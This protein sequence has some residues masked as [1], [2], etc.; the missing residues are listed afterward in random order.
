MKNGINTG[1]FLVKTG[2]RGNG[3]KNPSPIFV[4]TKTGPRKYGN[5]RIKVENGMNQNR[6]FSV[7]FQRYPQLGLLGADLEVHIEQ[8]PL[9]LGLNPTVHLEC[10][11]IF[12]PQRSRQ[13]VRSRQIRSYTP[14]R[15]STFEVARDL[16]HK[17][18]NSK[19]SNTSREIGSG[20][21]KPIRL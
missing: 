20:D 9:G 4:N 3:Q 18:N 17:G 16:S 6:N 21:L 11:L 14:T 19:I 1:Q 10:N 7:R 8:I 2:S 12:C 5:E 15:A 13:K